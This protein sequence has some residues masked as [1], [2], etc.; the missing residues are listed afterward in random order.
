MGLLIT[1]FTAKPSANVMMNMEKSEASPTGTLT[2][3]KK[4]VAEMTDNIIEISIV[5]VYF[6]SHGVLGSSR[7]FHR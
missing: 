4:N 6:W 1:W 2:L 7:I 3:E 5:I